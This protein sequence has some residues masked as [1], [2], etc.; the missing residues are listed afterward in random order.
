VIVYL[1]D[2][3]WAPTEHELEGAPW[4]YIEVDGKKYRREIIHG[5][6]GELDVSSVAYV[7]IS[8]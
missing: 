5:P 4:P 8:A 2:G 3:P 1:H 6:D 7:R